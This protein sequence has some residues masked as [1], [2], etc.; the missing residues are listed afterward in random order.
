MEIDETVA[1]REVLVMLRV[2]DNGPEEGVVRVRLSNLVNDSV[3]QVM[4]RSCKC[5]DFRFSGGLYIR[6]TREC[7]CRL[8]GDA[9][10]VFD[11]EVEIR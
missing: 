10:N 1:N 11:V 8:V 4:R 3:T 5:I 2:L 7:I 6:V 9:R